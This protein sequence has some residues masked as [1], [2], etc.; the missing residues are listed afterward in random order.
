[1]ID[2]IK[3]TPELRDYIERLH[4]ESRRYCD[5]LRTVRRDSCPM[6]DEEWDSSCQ[7]YRALCDEARVSLEEAM[8][9]IGEL[10]REEIAGRPYYVDFVACAICFG[11]SRTA[12]RRENRET[13]PDQ[14]TR[15]F[16]RQEPLQKLSINDSRCKDIT[17]QV[18]DACNMACT[19]CYQ[20]NKGNH[21]MSFDTAKRFVDMILDADDRTNGYITSTG[22][23]GAIFNFIGGEPWL[24]IDLISRISDYIIGELFRR[25]HPWA[26]KFMFGVCSNG[27]LHFDPRVQDYLRRHGGH[28]SYSISIDGNQELHDACRIDL[29]GKGTYERAMAAVRQYRE[30]LGGRMGSKMTIAPGNVDKV[31][32]A[33]ESMVTNG[34]RQINLN[35][36]Y[37]E[38]W[39]NE[40][41]AILYGQL[42]R[43]TDWLADQGLLD[44]VDLSIFTQFC[45]KPDPEDRNWCGGTGLMMAV[46][47]KGDIYPCLRY[48]ES[49]VGEKREPYI[50]GDLEHGIRREKAH[51]DR[52]DC[53]AC[54][55]R[56]SQSTDECWECPIAMGCGWCS[57]YNYECFG[58]PNKR[59]TYI[60]CMHKARALANVYYWRR[61][62]ED[63]PLNCPREWA[64][65]IIGAE[66]YDKLEAMKAEKGGAG[67]GKD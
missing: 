42:I 20:H 31:D 55:T 40:H 17:M 16:P 4:Y 28:L 13:Y 34:Y 67:N 48:M 23:D 11:D 8:A 32:Q 37:E 27:L 46:D 51:C 57:A 21:G 43:L 64:L 45:G 53:L 36:V 26:I 19:Y 38:G 7:Y 22:C 54:I 33:V 25:K 9:T 50:I 6:T 41:A 1:M 5:L 60:C 58:T 2:E 30:E 61:R 14:L 44:E 47:W 56:R 35:C 65:P 62:G 63:F 39:T 24:E 29:E 3:I 59:A 10:Y 15:L 18:T 49:S 66:E 12:P 52:V